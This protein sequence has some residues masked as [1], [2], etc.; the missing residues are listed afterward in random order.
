MKGYKEVAA[1][2]YNES[3]EAFALSKEAYES[4]K[5]LFSK[6]KGSKPIVTLVIKSNITAESLSFENLTSCSHI[7]LKKSQ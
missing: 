7:D 2:A 1:V 4:K 5:H 6:F 3:E